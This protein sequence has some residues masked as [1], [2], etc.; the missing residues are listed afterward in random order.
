MDM[1]RII[2]A[3]AMTNI[4]LVYHMDVKSTFLNGH[5]KE[6]VYVDQPQG[7]DAP[8]QEDKVYILKKVL[9]VLK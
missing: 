9:Y 7:Y 3:I 8:R 5:L 6:K 2:L 1:V 4:G